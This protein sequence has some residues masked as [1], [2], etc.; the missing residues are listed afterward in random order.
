[1]SKI[2]IDISLMTATCVLIVVAASTGDGNFKG[3][4]QG[5]YNFRIYASYESDPP[6]SVDAVSNPVGLATGGCHC[7]HL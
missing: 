3:C 5:H 1:M 4:A 6:N 7:A 2:D